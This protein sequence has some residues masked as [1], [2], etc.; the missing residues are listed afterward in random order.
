MYKLALADYINGVAVVLEFQDLR[1]R[2]GYKDGFIHAARM[3]WEDYG[4]FY[5]EEYGELGDEAYAILI[6]EEIGPDW[7]QYYTHPINMDLR[8][9]FPEAYVGK[10]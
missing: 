1:E 4:E 6:P 2:K 3:Y 5:M 10:K 8:E 7:E 9:Q